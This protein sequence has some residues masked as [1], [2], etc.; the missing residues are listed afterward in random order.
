MSDPLTK[1]QRDYIASL[2]LR[3]RMSARTAL[4][5]CP[6]VGSHDEIGNLTRDGASAMIAWL[7]TIRD[8]HTPLPSTRPEQTLF[9]RW[10]PR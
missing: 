3:N 2:L 5:Y 6:G 9:A 7:I 1:P 10:M 8:N 4:A